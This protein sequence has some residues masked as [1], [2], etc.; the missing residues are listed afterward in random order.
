MLSLDDGVMWIEDLCS[1]LSVPRLSKFGLKEEHI[2]LV[3]EKA[4]NSSSMKGKPC[5]SYRRRA[6]SY[7]KAG[8]LI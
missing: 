1:D 7:L 3:V 6:Y 2:P 4:K 5:P 8:H